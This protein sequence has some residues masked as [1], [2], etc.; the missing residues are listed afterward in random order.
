[1]YLPIDIQTASLHYTRTQVQHSSPANVTGI[2][3][4]D[5]GMHW[6]WVDWN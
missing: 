3:C 6:N 4:T 2:V 5:T 1:M